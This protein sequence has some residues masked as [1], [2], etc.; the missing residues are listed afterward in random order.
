MKPDQ[1]I[2]RFLKVS[3]RFEKN[4]NFKTFFLSILK[5]MKDTR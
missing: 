5:S 1:V 3:I 4:K 2:E